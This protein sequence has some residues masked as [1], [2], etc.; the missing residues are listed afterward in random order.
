MRFNKNRNS[1]NRVPSFVDINGYETVILEDT[2][3][4]S[5][6]KYIHMLVAETFIPNPEGKK[7]VR[8]KDGNLLNNRADNLEWTDE[9]EV[10]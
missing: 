9:P 7:Y 6:M 10:I 2:N 3:G 5:V 4:R 8:H 1:I